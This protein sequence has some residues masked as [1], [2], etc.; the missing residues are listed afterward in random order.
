MG[1]SRPA[2]G[3]RSRILQSTCDASTGYGLA[4]FKISHS[5]ELDEIVEATMRVNPYDDGWVCMRSPNGKDDLDI[6]R[7]S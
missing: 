5:A 4:N 2:C 6:V 1:S 7:A 3:A